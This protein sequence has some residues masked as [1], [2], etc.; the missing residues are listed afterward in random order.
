MDYT[1]KKKASHI[2]LDKTISVKPLRAA[3]Q[4]M[5][6]NFIRIP[7]KKDKKDKM[8]FIE[9][10]TKISFKY[11]EGGKYDMG[12]DGTDP[13]TDNKPIH[14][15]KLNNFY[16]SI[17]EITNEQFCIFLNEK[18]EQEDVIEGWINLNATWDDLTCGINRTTKGYSPKQGLK[19]HPVI[20]VSWYG[21]QMF[22]SWLSNKTGEIYR[23]PSEC[24]WEFV[25]RN[26][27]TK[28][29]YSWGNNQPV[30]KKGGN[31]ADERLK[32]IYNNLT[33]WPAYNDGFVYTS[34]VGS[35]NP[36]EAGIF[37]MTGNVAEWC[38]D[39]YDDLYYSSSTQD[40]PKGPSAGFKKVI[41]G[42]SWYIYSVELSNFAR[43]FESPDVQDF[44]I[45]F[46]LVKEI[47]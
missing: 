33:V 10:I 20:Y 7:E 13:E 47:K 25:A 23:L 9:P 3:K 17:Y 6:S 15:V 5:L 43:S 21:A 40:N 1:N 27:G 26:Y 32:K 38:S 31:I 8:M 34:P 45:G 37:D 14:S 35:F 44:D 11:I 36:S 29:K 28:N 19:N 16:I 4:I 24:E 2:T 30:G 18:K 39:W 46:R 42:G 12:N 22:C 41:R